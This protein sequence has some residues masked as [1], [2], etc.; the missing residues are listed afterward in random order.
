MT[1][2]Y[3]AVFVLT[4]ANVV[5]QIVVPTSGWSRAVAFALQIAALLVIV[6]T[7]RTR[8]G[9]RH[10]RSLAGAAVGVLAI[11]AVATGA[12]PDRVE[13]AGAAL[14]S[15]A[16]PL[17][18][19]GGL[20]R[21]V[22]TQGVTLQAVAG[23]LSIYLLIGLAFAA[24]IGLLARVDSAAYFESGVQPTQGNRVYFSFTVLTTTGFGDL[25]AA[26]P[27][28]QALAVVEML[29]GQIYLV[30]VIGVLV[31]SFGRRS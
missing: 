2:R 16:I 13:L 20:Y 1:F 6:A 31:G 10:T 21:L 5:W 25:T 12:Q 11:V 23:A 30:T 29:V 24:A 26:T 3:G 9:V 4:L 19:V 7:S 8:P 27:T 17:A 15:V 14:L 22:R 18:L 28:G